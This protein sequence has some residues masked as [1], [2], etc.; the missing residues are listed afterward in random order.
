[1]APA[2]RLT[3]ALTGTGGFAVSEAADDVGRLSPVGS[4]AG[5]TGGSGTFVSWWAGSA[6]RDGVVVEAGVT[7]S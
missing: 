3:S 5:L 1:M 6:E 2:A 4:G 7:V